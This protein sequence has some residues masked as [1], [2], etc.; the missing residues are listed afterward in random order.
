MKEV[1]ISV[2]DDLLVNF[3]DLIILVLGVNWQVCCLGVSVKV[4]STA[5]VNEFKH[6]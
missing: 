5:R 4:S 6:R 1:F 2:S 3:G